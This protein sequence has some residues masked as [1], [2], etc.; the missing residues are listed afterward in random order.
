MLPIVWCGVVYRQRM[1]GVP[2]NHPTSVLG[3]FPYYN[4]YNIFIPNPV[5][6]E[7]ARGRYIC[8]S[9]LITA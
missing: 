7:F 2:S 1:K 6:V 4:T 9:Y 8:G 3:D 5:L